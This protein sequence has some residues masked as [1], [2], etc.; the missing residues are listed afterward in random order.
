V[1]TMHAR[2]LAA[3]D[4]GITDRDA[5]VDRVVKGLSRAELVDLARPALRWQVGHAMR[6]RVRRVE[7]RVFR[8][9]RIA[10]TPKGGGGKVPVAAKSQPTSPDALRDILGLTFALRNGDRVTFRDATAEQHMARAAYL[11]E[12]AATDMQTASR[13][14]E[15]ARMIRAAGVLNLAEV[16]A[17]KKPSRRQKVAA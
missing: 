7:R 12:M 15:A 5:V 6:E 4:E 11:R 9:P 14:D 13:H 10:T 16:Y 17:A 3:L 8:I 2:I 1:K